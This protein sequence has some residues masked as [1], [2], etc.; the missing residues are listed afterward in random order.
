MNGSVFTLK[1]T[2]SK[3][4]QVS[5]LQPSSKIM[6]NAAQLCYLQVREILDEQPVPHQFN[7]LEECDEL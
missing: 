3:R 7:A 6:E 1:G 2:P 5:E 4:V